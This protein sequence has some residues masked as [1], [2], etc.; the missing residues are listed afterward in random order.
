[1]RKLEFVMILL[2]FIGYTVIIA[3]W[4]FYRIQLAENR[5]STFDA[6]EAVTFHKNNEIHSQLLSCVAENTKL[7]QMTWPKIKKIRRYWVHR[8]NGVHRFVDQKKPV[9]EL[10]D[11]IGGPE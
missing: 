10:L 6:V 2:F 4:A 8:A 1:M 7:R 5:I 3:M 9:N 11:G